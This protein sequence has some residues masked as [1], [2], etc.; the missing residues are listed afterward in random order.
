MILFSIPVHEK[1]EVVENQIQNFLKYNPGASILLHISKQMPPK[2]VAQVRQLTRTYPQ[3]FINPIQLYT[4]WADGC[5]FKIHL[6]NFQYALNQQIPFQY[7]ALHASNDLFIQRGLQQYIQNYD[8]GFDA[9][10]PLKYNPV[11]QQKINLEKHFFFRRLMK[12]NKLK[13]VIPSQVEG[14]FYRRDIVEILCNR[15]NPK[16]TYDFPYLFSIGYHSKNSIRYKLFSFIEKVLR[17]L[18]ITVIHPNPLEEV[19]F[20]TFAADKIQQPLTFP[21]CYV[22]WANGLNITQEEITAIR[23]NDKP[24][25]AQH[26]KQLS[27]LTSQQL[28]SIEFFAVKRIN[29]D[30]SDPL[31]IYITQELD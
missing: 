29:R 15:L 27:H 26:C 13:T 5:Q 14:T 30:I 6:S 16:N 22:N 2:E 4:G 9:I 31:R 12:K 8:A 10:T 7:I 11:A 24:A 21:Y 18:N 19:F 28:Q 20:P 3:L 17:N 1:P 23:N 25:W